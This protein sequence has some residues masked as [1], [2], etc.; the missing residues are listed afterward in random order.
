MRYH[1]I[2]MK[3][4][5]QDQWRRVLKQNPRGGRTRDASDD[6]LTVKAVL[7]MLGY[8]DAIVEARD[9]YMKGDPLGLVVHA[10]DPSCL[11]HLPISPEFM[12]ILAP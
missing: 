1:E 6:C 3:L 9:A 8:A 4:T 12:G 5:P 7:R 2:Y 11:S 10:V